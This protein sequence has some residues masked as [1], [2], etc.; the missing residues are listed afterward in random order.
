MQKKVNKYFLGLMIFATCIFFIFLVDL[1]YS[2]TLDDAKKNHQVQQLEMAKVVSEGTRYFLYHLVKDMEFITSNPTLTHKNNSLLKDFINQFRLNYDHTILSSII[3]LDENSN[4]K[5][6]SG[7]EPPKW[8]NNLHN[9]IFYFFNND[10]AH[11]SFYVSKV[12]PDSISD[13]KSEKSFLIIMP[14]KNNNEYAAFLINF[15]S[16]IKNFITPLK[17]SNN[18]FVWILDGEGRLIY[19]PRHQEMLFNSILNMRNECLSCHKTFDDQK[20]IMTSS[21]PNFGE[22]LVKGDEPSKIFAYVPMQI[23]NQRWNIAISTLLPDV[24]AGLKSRFKLFFIL[25][26]IILATLLSFLFIIYYLNMRRIKSEED[27]KNIERIRDFQ[28]QLNHSSR[29]AS[30]GELVDSVAH[31]LNTPMGIIS[32]HAD[33]ILL[34]DGAEPEL[35]EELEIIKKQT[36]RVSD[37]TRTILNFSKRMPFEPKEMD[38]ISLADESLYILSP[39]IREKRIKVIK[40]YPEYSLNIWGDQNQ[41]EQVFINLLNNSIDAVE[42]GG[43]ITVEMKH[44][45][46]KEK[47]FKRGKNGSIM[48]I[49]NDNG[50]GINEDNINKVFEPFFTTKISGTGLGLSIVRSII[51]RHKGTIEV[52]SKKG[53][54]T[55]FCIT[56]PE[57]ENKNE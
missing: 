5:Y 30:I 8:F 56:L 22:Y 14:F 18:D 48:V 2:M 35:R 27:T 54:M 16:L 49:I 23:E 33:S 15:D 3:L 55:E 52:K 45:Y 50:S 19:H 31:E 12:Y 28:E 26:V 1:I 57:W 11:Y 6:V 41:L 21:T 38:I 51:I 43:L 9:E 25:G 46:K 42:P 29:L 17:L 36:R 47:I 13:I 44:F 37:Y 7:K 40:Y 20:K 39:K 32:A 4:I 10:T 34:R 53:E 24:I